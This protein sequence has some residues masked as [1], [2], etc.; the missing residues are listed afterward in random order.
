MFS[1]PRRVATL[2]S[3]ACAIVL[4][5]CDFSEK[6]SGPAA[7]PVEPA[8]ASASVGAAIRAQN[9]HTDMLM[10]ERGV[11]GTAVGLLSNGRAVVQVFVLDDTPRRIPETLDDSVPVLVRVTGMLVAYSDPTTRLRPAPIGFSV[12][13]PSITAGTIGARVV[14]GAGT[15]FVLSNNHV[16]AASNAASIGDPILQPGTFDGGTAADQIATLSAFNPINFQG[17]LNV[18]DAA[19]AQSDHTFLANFTP[20]DDGYGTPSSIIFGD[21]NNDRVFDNVA[22]LLNFT[23]QKFGRTTKLTH[24]V[25]SAVNATLD[26]CY[27]VVFI[28]C[29]KSARF[30]DQIVIAGNGFSSGGDSGSLIVTDNATLNPVGLLFAG[31]A[32]QTIANRIDLVLNHFN[33]TVDG[34][35]E[36]PPPPDPV[37]DAMM[38][39]INAASSI[40]QGRT[41][42]VGAV[43][44]N[45]GNQPTAAFDVTMRDQ[46][47][48][49]DIG[50][51]TVPAM[52]VG[53]QEAVAF[54]WNTTGRSIGAHTLVASHNLTDANAANNQVAKTVQITPPIVPLT[55]VAV[56]AINVPASVTR[57]SNV[58]VGVTVRNAGNQNVGA[59]DVAL[60]DQTDNLA[61][62]TQTV[63][64]LAPGAT[65][66]LTFTWS[67]ASSTLGTHT[68]VA[69]HNLADDNA[70]NNQAT[71]S[72][73]VSEVTANAIHIGD[74]DPSAMNSGGNRWSATV[75]I[76]VHDANHNRINGATAVGAWNRPGLASDTC[77]SGEL[78]TLGRCL[79]LFPS[80]SKLMA[81]V[82]FSVG[83]V[84]MSG[85]TYVPS[86]NHD[87]DGS[88]NGTTQKVNRP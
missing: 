46:T 44:R 19:L 59:F 49:V 41:V 36:P 57:G 68:L 64:G 88:S 4:A 67:T 66:T 77:T 2:S 80:L 20:A 26:I 55:D 37:V 28:S 34:S 24:G 33:V 50:T 15:V 72:V 73:Q 48:G 1:L 11:V 60:Q 74:L 7:V 6:I 54:S 13:H 84:T 58:S 69:S 25:I 47:D 71:A 38:V 76:E 39:G 23:V 32:T 61:I 42:F 85:R 53:G 43:V 3:A 16:L 51:A 87:P 83:S 22:A 56:T 52:A 40:E 30:T 63:A 79:V 5:S 29:T 82:S 31:S 70:A 12:G 21:A 45:V 86:Q 35:T 81:T 8:P 14:N 78:G 27:E 18:M 75:H 62:G 9:R 65:A 10:R 17:G